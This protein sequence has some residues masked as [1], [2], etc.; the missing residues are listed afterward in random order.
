MSLQRRVYPR[1]EGSAHQGLSWPPGHG[2]SVLQAMCQEPFVISFHNTAQQCDMVDFKVAHLG[3]CWDSPARVQVQS[4][5]SL[6]RTYSL[7]AQNLGSSCELVRPLD[8]QTLF[9]L[10]TLSWF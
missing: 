9:S 2:T 8:A 6:H 4:P 10:P 1:V 5:F 3:L 7:C